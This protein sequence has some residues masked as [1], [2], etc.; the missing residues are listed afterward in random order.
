MFINRLYLND[1]ELNKLKKIGQGTDGRVF[2]YS[3]DTLVKVYLENLYKEHDYENI[4]NLED[5]VYSKD[6]IVLKK[7]EEKI[8]YYANDSEDR[9]KIRTKDAIIKA[10]ERQEYI[11]NTNLP[12]GMVF[13]NKKF[14]GCLLKKV[15]GMQ[16]HKLTGMPMSYKLSIIKNALENIQELLDNN[17]YHVDLNNSPFVKNGVM[18]DGKLNFEYGHSHI[19]VDPITKK[20]NII[21]LDGKSTIYTERENEELYNKC[22]SGLCVLLTEFLYKV[23][24]E[25]KEVDE[26]IY[27]LTSNGLNYDFADRLANGNFENINEIKKELKLI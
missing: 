1:N 14:A 23:N 27:E 7:D 19:L 8:N 20:A 18:I 5:K 24:P 25:N 4:L 13:V 12:C 9:I 15:N 21:D 10:I 26:I 22:L 11:K 6:K 3:N 2:K 17:V 16:I